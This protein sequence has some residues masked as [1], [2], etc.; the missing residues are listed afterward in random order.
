[1]FNGVNSPENAGRPAS[2]C[3][4]EGLKMSFPS[5]SFALTTR[6]L[7]IE[8]LFVFSVALFLFLS[9]RIPRRSSYLNFCHIARFIVSCTQGVEKRERKRE[10]ERGNT[11][12]IPLFLDMGWLCLV[13]W[14]QTN[15]EKTR[16]QER[17]GSLDP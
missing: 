9:V 2:P 16:D 14:T 1:M 15:N 4:G 10:R 3:N 8:G 12:V 17:L 5:I 6:E 7:L 13:R 11:E